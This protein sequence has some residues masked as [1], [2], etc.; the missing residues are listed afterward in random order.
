M[1][2]RIARIGTNKHFAAKTH[3]SFKI[4]SDCN[5]KHTRANLWGYDQLL[6]WKFQ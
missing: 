5:S 1:Y 3:F 2:T 4:W 6:Q